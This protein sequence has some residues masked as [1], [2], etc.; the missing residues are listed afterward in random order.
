MKNVRKK[1]YNVNLTTKDGQSKRV[2]SCIEC[3]KTY[4]TPKKAKI[5]Y[6][7]VCGKSEQKKRKKNNMHEIYAKKVIQTQCFTKTEN[8]TKNEEFESSSESG[9]EDEKNCDNDEH[10]NKDNGS[11]LVAIK[12][13]IKY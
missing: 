7:S 4:T 12:F 2:Y 11:N 1:K 10:L 6:E 3:K 9:L 8:S 5:H 13:P